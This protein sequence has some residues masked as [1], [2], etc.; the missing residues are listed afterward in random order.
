MKIYLHTVLILSLSSALQSLALDISKE[1]IAEAAKECKTRIDFDAAFATDD[2]STHETCKF[3]DGS[4]A[5]S[6]CNLKAENAC[7]VCSDTS[8][9]CNSVSFITKFRKLWSMPFFDLTSLNKEIVYDLHHVVI[10]AGISANNEVAICDSN[11]VTDLLVQERE[12]KVLSAIE[13][14]NIFPFDNNEV[15]FSDFFP[16]TPTYLNSLQTT[17][18]P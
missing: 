12:A 10:K 4:S 6:S 11:D 16:V 15:I 17:G 1:Q 13:N 7:V 5:K 2:G 18:L 3:C 8:D 14:D 9:K